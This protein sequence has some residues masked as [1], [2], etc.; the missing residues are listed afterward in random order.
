M[1][2]LVAAAFGWALRGW[3]AAVLAAVSY[4]SVWTM[5]QGLRLVLFQPR[6]SPDLVRVIGHL[7]GSAFPSTF[8]LA[9]PGTVGFVAVLA[10]TAG[11]AVWRM[12][13]FVVCAALLPVGFGARVAL[14]AH[15]PS[16]VLLSGLLGFLWISAL[17]AFERRTGTGHAKPTV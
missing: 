6:P 8:A 16:D 7:P 2:V 12:F 15:W 13:L 5:E 10:L 14:G 11:P 4:A 17:L 9:Y 1:L 3:L